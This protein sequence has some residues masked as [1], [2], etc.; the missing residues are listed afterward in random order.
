MGK[1]MSQIMIVNKF[2]VI[3]V[4][5]VCIVSNGYTDFGRIFR[6]SKVSTITTSFELNG[7]DKSM[8]NNLEKSLDTSMNETFPL[9]DSGSSTSRSVTQTLPNIPRVN[10]EKER[11]LKVYVPRNAKNLTEVPNRFRG[12]GKKSSVTSRSLTLQPKNRFRAL[13]FDHLATSS[14]YAV[15]SLP[16]L[17]YRK[18]NKYLHRWW[19]SAKKWNLLSGEMLEIDSKLSTSSS[20]GSDLITDH[21]DLES[22]NDDE[23]M[24]MDVD[25]EDD[26]IETDDDDII[27]SDENDA[28]DSNDDG[29]GTDDDEVEDL[30]SVSDELD[31]SVIDGDNDISEESI[32]ES[33][34]VDILMKLYD[35]DVDSNYTSYL[36]NG[37]G[38]GINNSSDNNVTIPYM[39]L[40]ELSKKY[41]ARVIVIGDIH[42]CIEEMCD[43]LRQVHYR[44]GDLVLLLGDLVAKGP[45]SREVIQLAMDIG[46][47]CIR[48]NHE[49]EV[50]RQGLLLRRKS[51]STADKRPTRR[52][53]EHHR[54][55]MQLNSK[56]FRWLCHLPYYVRCA[57]LGSL[58]V[59]AG[60]CAGVRLTEQDPWM[61]LTM[62]S[63]LPDGRVSQRCFYKYPWANQWRGPLTVYFGHDAARGLQVHS[64]AVG[65]D[66]G[67][68]NER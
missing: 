31:S 36:G 19:L 63:L 65:L 58:F 30:V 51:T 47:L 43:L 44:P 48:G 14:L 66:T 53:S 4:L 17:R 40:Y 64:N 1:T 50:I 10:L 67:N 28:D 24:K 55:A 42:G 32:L 54:I 3:I 56:E 26:V 7:L 9:Q 34:K 41:S 11:N 8:D 27:I 22:S 61:M 5:I 20:T 6:F 59:H 38:S 33:S 57:D 37:I 12:A 45:F 46:A 15:E 29:D 39:Q 62:R 18:G 60:F 52:K 21:F 2:A 16:Y 35:E 68:C 25:G 23:L 49:H 13:S